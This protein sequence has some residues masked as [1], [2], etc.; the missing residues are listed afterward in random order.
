MGK[1]NFDFDYVI[2]GSGSAGSAAANLAAEAGLK[3]AVVEANSWGGTGLNGSDTASFAAFSASHLYSEAVNGVRFGLS[4]S[5][6][7][8]N[9]PTMLNWQAFAEKRATVNQKKSFED[10]GVTCFHGFANFL[11]PYEI[12]VGTKRITA[13]HFLIATGASLFNGNISGLESVVCLNPSSALKLKRLPKTIFIVGG[14]STGCELAQYFAE[15]G[16]GTYLGETSSRLLPRE[17]AEAG[18]IIEL[19]LEECCKTKILTQSRVISVENVSNGKKVT[20]LRGGAEKTVIVDEIVLAT[21]TR[22]IIDLGLENT[23]VKY[24]PSGIK[25]DRYLQ[26]SVKHIY[27]AGDVL[28]SHISSAERASY[29]GTL[30]TANIIN[31][32]RNVANYSGYIRMTNTYP[33][34]ATTGLTEEECI[35]KNI[36]TKSSVTTLSSVPAANIHDFRAGFVKITINAATNKII[37]ATVVCPNADVVIQELAFAVR[38]GL[39]PLHIASAPHV[40][41]GWSEAVHTAARKLAK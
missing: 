30:A 13:S 11:S 3:T 36:K 19:Y 18:K 41:S 9:Y 2:I 23:G 21:G 16:V 20:F 38:H 25:V 10:L 6:L 29:E 34:I 14:G 32:T 26:T 40:A 35:T 15:L 1:K 31:R 39:T 27:A 12:S 28:G 22:P 4:S 7:K 24:T 5:S 17:D 37:G 8:F 33:A